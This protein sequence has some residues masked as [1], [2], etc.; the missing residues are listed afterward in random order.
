MELVK[1]G[2][3]ALSER[4]TLSEDEEK[5]IDE[6]EGVDESRKDSGV[7]PKPPKATKKLHETLSLAES[8]IAMKKQSAQQ[9]RRDAIMM[10]GLRWAYRMRMEERRLGRALY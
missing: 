2:E 9:V 10:D 4:Y 5:D 6:Q 3:R 8:L 7:V 1:N